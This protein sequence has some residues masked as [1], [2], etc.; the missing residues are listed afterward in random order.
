MSRLP[1]AFLGL[2]VYPE[3]LVWPNVAAFVISA[4]RNSPSSEIVLIT[5][6][7]G[8]GDRAE[9]QRHR[10]SSLPLSD[11]CP[12]GS[13]ADPEHRRRKKQWVMSLYAKRHL[14]YAH[15]L[16]RMASHH[17][18]LTDTRD[19]VVAGDLSALGAGGSLLF[20]Q[21]NATLSLGSEATNRGWIVR[22][23]G[24]E[25]VGKL[26]ARRILC[27]GTVYGPSDALLAYAQAMC[28]ECI[29]IGIARLAEAGDQPI[30]NYLA[31]SG[32]LP[33]YRISSAEAGGI[34]T[35]G[36][37]PKRRFVAG[38]VRDCLLPS[39]RSSTVIYHQYDRHMNSRVVRWA[40]QQTTGDSNFQS[41][42][43]LS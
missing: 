19:V 4:R 15:A 40:L 25:E 31:Y 37:L 5:S 30:H 26:H 24:K 6:N 21:E 29:R 10:V 35:V 42:S 39:G 38:W 43:D 2:A 32:L 9:F 14:Y 17:V 41:W 16:E 23:Y 22:A 13:E 20:A 34:K 27:A 36:L 7:L 3:N 33:V 12:V 8:E 11:P 28:Q 1:T 18:L